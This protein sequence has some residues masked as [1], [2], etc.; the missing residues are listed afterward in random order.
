MVTAEPGAGVS[1]VIV[2]GGH[3]EVRDAMV[4]ALLARGQHAAAFETADVR[5]G[6]GPR[7]SALVVILTRS[8][9]ELDL[10]AWAAGSPVRVVAV[11]GPADVRGREAARQAG[12]DVLL[13]RSGRTSPLTDA[14]LAPIS[15]SIGGS[16]P[17]G[18]PDQPHAEDTRSA[19]PTR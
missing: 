16:D 11:H 10:I 8:A 7:T 9:D 3:P 13:P 5:S 15:R 17:A 14:L 2:C 1:G 12:A 6:V 18:L 4:A 19:R